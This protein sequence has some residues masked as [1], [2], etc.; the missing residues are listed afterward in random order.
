[1]TD[2]AYDLVV[3]GSGAAGLTAALTAADHGARVL[4]IEKG[5]CYGGTSAT[6]GG[7]LWIPCNHLMKDVGIEDNDADALRYLTALTRDDVPRANVEAFVAHGRRM[8]AWLCGNSEV[9]YMATPASSAT[10]SSTCSV[11]MC[12]RVCSG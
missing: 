7:G 9:R 11:R 12:R 1:M 10:I 8:L 2:T 5:A 4:V 3:L 6:S